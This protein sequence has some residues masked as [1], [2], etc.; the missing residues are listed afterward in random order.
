MGDGGGF[1]VEARGVAGQEGLS[2]SPG[3]GKREGGGC[4]PPHLQTSTEQGSLKPEAPERR[5]AQ[6]SFPPGGCGRAKQQLPSLARHLETVSSPCQRAK[7]KGAPP[8][9]RP[10][11][12]RPGQIQLE[13]AGPSLVGGPFP[14]ARGIIPG[15]EQTG[16]A[17]GT[18]P[19][20]QQSYPK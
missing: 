6:P 20:E 4:H 10:G 2:Y 3:V 7:S 16:G 11:Q 14:C 5:L 15:C 1:R 13:A 18:S 9:P 19:T 17:G 12:R 8:L